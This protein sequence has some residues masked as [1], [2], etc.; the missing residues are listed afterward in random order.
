MAR[1]AASCCFFR[2]LALG[3]KSAA[4]R[5]LHG[6][7]CLL[8]L[9]IATTSTSVRAGAVSAP[10]PQVLT[11]HKVRSVTVAARRDAGRMKWGAAENRTW[12]RS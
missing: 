3:E 8:G 5:L 7:C 1:L 12:F 11:Q 4:E 10:R 9:Q 6:H 2:E